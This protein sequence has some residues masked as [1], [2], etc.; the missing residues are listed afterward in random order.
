MS[1]SISSLVSVTENRA[2][3]RASA[4]AR[5]GLRSGGAAMLPDG[6]A[7]LGRRR[8]RSFHG[9]RAGAASAAA[10]RS[11]SASSLL[12]ASTSWR[13]LS[14]FSLTTASFPGEF[15]AVAS[16]A[17]LTWAQRRARWLPHVLS[18]GND[19][20]AAAWRAFDVTAAAAASA[21]G[22]GGGGGRG[23]AEITMA[24]GD[25]VRRARI[26]EQPLAA[27]GA[28]QQRREEREE[29]REGRCVLVLGSRRRK[30]GAK[31]K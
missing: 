2:R 17:L 13:W 30:C 19:V 29:R 16:P 10:T 14:A 25:V 15:L 21:T 5:D 22:S 26:L 11:A 28:G 23:S 9:G 31:I 7:S 27:A 18:D 6:A 12:P 8:V 3:S 4:Q 1:S 24:V 20:T